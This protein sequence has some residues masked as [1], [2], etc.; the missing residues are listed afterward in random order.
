MK[1]KKFLVFFM[2]AFFSS[3][4][5]SNYAFASKTKN[6]RIKFE[7]K[8]VINAEIASTQKEKA[9]GL[10]HRQSMNEDE[11]MLFVF[12]YASNYSF[13]TKNMNFAIDIIWIGADFRIVDITED[14]E[15]CKSI[16]KCKSYMP[17]KKAKYVIEVVS[18]F[19]DKNNLTIGQKIDVFADISG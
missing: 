13:W 3:V 5:L 8:R 11:G 10:M 16:E 15:P 14:A 19:A 4:L 7:N 6:V 2:L 12:D 18:G 17:A 1:S 9:L